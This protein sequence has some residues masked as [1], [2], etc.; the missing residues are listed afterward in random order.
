MVV[1][2]TLI[3]ASDFTVCSEPSCRIGARASS[4]VLTC[5]TG[6]VLC[7]RA[8]NWLV[9]TTLVQTLLVGS[10]TAVAVE[11][12]LEPVNRA[13][14]AFNDAA[15]R[16]GLRPVAKAYD[17]VMPIPGRIGVNNFFT[18]LLDVNNALNAF[19]QGQMR[20]A[21]DTSLRVV[22][23]STLG[24]LGFFD[25]ASDMGI[26]RY[27][28]DF[29]QTM[30]RWGIPQGPYV[31]LPLLGPRTARAGVGVFVDGWA[32]PMGQVNDQELEWGLRSADVINFRA[33]LLGAD[34]LLSGDRYIF[35]R[36]AYLQTRAQQ[37]GGGNVVDDFSTFDDDWESDPL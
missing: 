21:A 27:A 28:T 30:A 14:F 35:F 5:L 17:A 4:R 10:A 6:S 2:V 16:Y 26:P 29:G 13:I 9:A 36:D 12:P 34:E 32:S 24:F 22:V 3:S 18:N 8:L 33:G 23:N 1:P 7:L 31:V 11:D 19:L 25:V 15:D 37:L 20:G